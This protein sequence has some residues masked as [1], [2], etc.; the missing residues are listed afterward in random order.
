MGLAALSHRD[1]PWTAHVLGL[2][3]TGR[4]RSALRLVTGPAARASE[5]VK[6]LV[7]NACRTSLL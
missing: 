1:S 6:S 3:K 7:P 5:V 4:A 2:A